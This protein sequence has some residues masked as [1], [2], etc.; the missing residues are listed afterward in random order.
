MT[1]VY[2][3]GVFLPAAEARVQADDAALLFGRGLYETF[4]ARR[5]TVYRLEQHVQRLRAGAEVLGIP[6]PREVDAL[7][8]IV[9]ELVERSGL[10]DARVRL[11]LTAGP[12][13]GRPS[14]LV[15]ARDVTDYPAALY[16]TGMTAVTASVRRNETSPLSRIK[17]LNC[18]DNVMSR[19]QARQ[20]GASMALLL[21]TRGLVAEASA[22]N[23]FAVRDGRLVTPPVE[24]GAL[25]GVTRAAVLDIAGAC[26][27][28]AYES[29]LA[30]GDLFA[31]D[32]AFLTGA[33]MGVMPL[34]SIDG[35]P[36]ASGRP[37]RLTRRLRQVYEE[38]AGAAGPSAGAEC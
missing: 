5:G 31:A 25:P 13:G 19:E 36:L 9:R 10:G 12:P 6:V 18:L 24:D 14:L 28:P 20:M 22:A 16:E 26:G 23:V 38:V 17:S 8:Q 7:A 4:R 2:L 32:E 1:V 11:T 15:Q 35:R 29:S 37:G 3:D 30:L 34:V 27:I 33:I 21:N